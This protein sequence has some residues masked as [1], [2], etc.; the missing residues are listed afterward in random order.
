MAEARGL[1]AAH[2]FSETF[3]TPAERICMKFHQALEFVY[4]EVLLQHLQ[5]HVCRPLRPQNLKQSQRLNWLL[6]PELWK[7]LHSSA[8]AC[9]P[10]SSSF[11]MFLFKYPTDL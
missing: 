1:K 5:L 9:F 11:I 6:K 3:P 7:F 8:H 2:A 4:L 10:P